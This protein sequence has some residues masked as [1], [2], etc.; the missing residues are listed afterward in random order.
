MVKLN[1]VVTEYA[2]KTIHLRLS[3]R[4]QGVGFR[5]YIFRIATQLGISGWVRNQRGEVEIVASGTSDD[6]ALFM[7]RLTTEA[8][9]IS[10]PQIIYHQTRLD[11][12]LSPNNEI[13]KFSII[14]SAEDS[15]SAAHLPLDLDCCPDCLGELFD[16]S[17]HR[18]RDPFI[19]C[20]QCGPRYTAINRLPYDRI[21]TSM[22]HFSRCD[23]CNDEYRDPH[24]RRFHAEAT[25]CPD[26]GPQLMWIED[27]KRIIQTEDALN[28][29][30]QALIADKIVAIKGIGGYHL[31][32]S[33]DSDVGIT[34]LR[35]NKSRPAKPFA[36]MF[37][38]QG[39]DS[40]EALRRELV[41]S[42]VERVLLTGRCRPVVLCDRRSDSTLSTLISPDTN[43][44]GAMLPYSPL[45][46]LILHDFGRP[47]IA[48]SANISGEPVMTD[49]DEVE[50]KLNGVADAF[51]HHNR[52]II[53]AIDDSVFQVIHRKPR[54]LRLGRGHAPLELLL[55][56]KLRQPLL[57]VGGEMK[58]SVALAWDDRVVISPHIGELGSPR[59]AEFFKE[60]I[61]TLQQQYGVTASKT[62]CDAHPNYFSHRWAKSFEQ[63]PIEVYH[64]HAHA[65]AVVGE[66]N[67]NQTSLVFTWDGSGLGDDATLWG[68]EALLGRPGN[69][70][71]AATFRPF[72]L[73]GGEI[74]AREP[75]RCAAALSWQAGV[76]WNDHPQAELLHK[77][78]QNQI[79]AP[80]TSS[81]GRL[82]DGAAAQLE[83]IAQTSYEGQA[84]MVL[85]AA[86]EAA[87]IEEADPLPYH[88][89]NNGLLVSD[90]S[91][92]LALFNDNTKTISQRA[93]HFHSTL[94]HTLCQQAVTLRQQHG[95]FVVGLNGG[96]F[97]NRL[98]TE[99]AINLL[100]QQGF[101]VYLPQRLPCNDG[102]LCFGQIIEAAAQL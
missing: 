20:S 56:F 97:Q 91:P 84:A 15:N 4:V 57:A 102:A 66:Y 14:N 25:C 61:A 70:Q 58:S 5:P 48:T 54:P 40:V 18:H 59:S 36:V 89:E 28:E 100:E 67:I 76:D 78:W 19:N 21:N 32:C 96:V 64:H 77:A 3:G 92:L 6:I 82:F 1:P 98:L 65:A 53:H 37:P 51:L 47:V 16:P 38:Q 86:A 33:A 85:Q 45:H 101:E 24:N 93:A 81:V 49:A 10:S 69:W 34:R 30:Q 74:A 22:T 94:A 43:R 83:L 80:L 8:P 60:T 99:Q 55:P 75:W 12:G 62:V 71:R 7:H 52:E 79:N 29:V 87:Q 90:W 35:H 9:A 72:R 68:G 63:P 41:I 46:H 73:P 2:L 44:I 50:S 13:V 11:S 39:D 26:C 42:D 27:D 95:G 17:N 23:R 31:L 88:I